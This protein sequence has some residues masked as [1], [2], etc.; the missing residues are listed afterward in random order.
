M[1]ERAKISPE[2][3]QTIL[4]DEVTGRLRDLMEFMQNTVAEGGLD[5][6]TITITDESQEVRFGRWLS[7]NIT[8]DGPNDVYVYFQRKLPSTL[9]SGLKSGE[10][11]RLDQG[12]KV[13][14]SIYPV[15]KTGESAKI[16]TWVVS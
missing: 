6:P 10:S 8:N 15:C 14:R 12:Y 1:E 7:I 5:L 11:I 3:M 9:D 13:A 16:R 4:L 2:A